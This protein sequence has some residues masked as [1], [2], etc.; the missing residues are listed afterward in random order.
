MG[1]AS[2]LGVLILGLIGGGLLGYLVGGLR[3]ELFDR[4]LRH[5]N[6][7]L[8]SL[9]LDRDLL[10]ETLEITRRELDEVRTEAARERAAAPLKIYGPSGGAPAIAARMLTVEI[11][12]QQLEKLSSKANRRDVEVVID[13]TDKARNGAKTPRTVSRSRKVVKANEPA[14]NPR[15]RSPKNLPTQVEEPDSSTLP[16]LEYPEVRFG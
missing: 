6:T 16:D 11:T 8:R 10:A 13:D 3:R 14:K 9:E 7:R 2:I 1:D 4:N 12:R 5:A 15:R